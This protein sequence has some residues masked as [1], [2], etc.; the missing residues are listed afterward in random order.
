MTR[1]ISDPACGGTRARVRA[2]AR[3][4]TRVCTCVLAMVSVPQRSGWEGYLISLFLMV[5]RGC[6][7]GCLG[8]LPGPGALEPSILHLL[9]QK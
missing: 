1:W 8:G 6:S 7:Q 9:L 3:A 4:P 5:N 2:G